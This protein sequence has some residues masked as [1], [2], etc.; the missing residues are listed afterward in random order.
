MT[1]KKDDYVFPF[2]LTAIR[3]AQS[4]HVHSGKIE[5]KYKEKWEVLHV[6]HWNEKLGFLTCTSL[7]FPGLVK[8][9]RLREYRNH[10]RFENFGCQD[11]KNTLVCCPKEPGE[12][13]DLSLV[14]D[15]AVVCEQGKAHHNSRTIFFAQILCILHISHFLR[16]VVINWVIQSSITT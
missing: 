8:N 15:V 10:N 16:I 3:L 11:I 5:M 9:L 2:S 1:L 13:N 7:G 14:R 12:Q 4:H 6:K